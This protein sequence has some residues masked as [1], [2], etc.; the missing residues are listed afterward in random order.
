[1]DDLRGIKDLKYAMKAAGKSVHFAASVAGAKSVAASL[2]GKSRA[3][4]IGGKSHMSAGGRSSAGAGAGK[5]THH[6]GERFKP[7]KSGTGGDVK[8]G[9]KVEPY[10]YWS[11]DR[12]MLNR[13]AGKK[14]GASK[15]LATVVRAAKAGA[16]RGAKAKRQRID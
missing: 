12:K 1:M 16:A 13:R 7:K 11:F 14:A 2:G 15:N 6:S 10:A 3:S 9:Q 5:G 8:G 4:S